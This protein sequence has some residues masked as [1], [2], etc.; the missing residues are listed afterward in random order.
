LTAIYIHIPFCAYKCHYCDFATSTRTEEFAKQYCQTLEREI[1]ARLTEIADKPHISTIFYGGG[2]P[3]L[4]DTQ[5][6]SQIHE[7]LLKNIV[8][9]PDNEI[10][11]E[12]NPETITGVKAKVWRELGINRL[13]IGIQSFND[14][15]LTALGRGHCSI[16]AIKAIETASKAGFN[17]I[18]CDLMYGIPGQNLISW[19]NSISSFI[20]LANKYSQI[21]H[22]SAYGL[23][24]SPAAPLI[25]M[26]PPNSN[27]YPSEEVFEEQLRYLITELEEA[28]FMQYEISNFAKKGYECRH[29]LNYWQQGEYYAFGV[30]AHRYI[31]PYRSS[32]WRSLGRYLDD[33][34]TNETYELIDQDLARTEAL[35]LGLRMNEGLNLKQ[36][37][38]S[39]NENLLDSHALTIEKLITHNLLTHADGQLKLTILG[40]PVANT[41]IGEFLQ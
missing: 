5:Y 40:Q 19:Q 6:L 7:T 29:N 28:G 10:S 20:E 24:L 37:E 34:L 9:L 15:E 16:D 12:T 22:V 25:K 23:E 11:L 32:N 14:T 35:M 3:G 30:S 38:Q 21:K 4:L 2:T 17:N 31:K 39:Y 33:C 1:I 18:N 27:A 8:L 13:S 41:I 26:I 36:F